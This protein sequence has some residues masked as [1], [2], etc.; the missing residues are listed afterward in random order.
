MKPNNQ[1]KFV[2][3]NSYRDKPYRKEE[4]K[5]NTGPAFSE[6]STGMVIVPSK[7]TLTP[8]VIMFQDAYQH[9]QEA[10]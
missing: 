3:A 9:L 5:L 2:S 7:G 6:R 4:I 8:V 10:M 1:A